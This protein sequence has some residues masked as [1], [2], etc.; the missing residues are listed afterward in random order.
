MY[1]QYTPNNSGGSYWHT[2]KEWE[3]L[4]SLGWIDIGWSIMKKFP[5]AAE[6][7]EEWKRIMQ[8]DPEAEGCECCGPPHNF[9]T[10]DDKEAELFI[11]AQL[12]DILDD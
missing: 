11:Q 2:D 8:M 3:T 1:L 5:S 7:M 9:D 6:G 12:Q 4:K 10:W